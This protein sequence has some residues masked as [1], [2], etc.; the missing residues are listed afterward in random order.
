MPI[1]LN[2]DFKGANHPNSHWVMGSLNLNLPGKTATLIMFG[3]HD[4]D[5]FDA[6]RADVLDS[7]SFT[8]TEPNTFDFYFDEINRVSETCYV[9]QIENWLVVGGP[10]GIEDP[11]R[12]FFAG[13]TVSSA[14]DF[15]S[16]EVGDVSNTIVAV[17]FTDIVAASNFLTGVT[18]KV[19]G[20]AVGISSAAQPANQAIVEFTMAA[21][22][23]VGATITFEYTPGNYVDQN[24]ITL[25]KVPADTVTNNLGRAMRFNLPDNS[26]HLS[27]AF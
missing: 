6:D 2:Y 22:I 4:K 12:D 27:T 17:T 7:Q 14:V 24:A 3:Y 1:T 18:I 11:P 26:I 9:N 13:G 25:S 16:A 19:N 10:G 23:V 8:C 5:A 15:K 21:P 20:G